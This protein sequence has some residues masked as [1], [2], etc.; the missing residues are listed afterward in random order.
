MI[1]EI[2]ALNP[3]TVSRGFWNGDF[4][5]TKE[6]GSM[7]KE[8]RILQWHPAFYAGVQLELEKEA[9]E[10]AFDNE[11]QLGTKPREIDVLII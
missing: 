1:S 10:L 4:L 8:S 11:H 7:G 2:H 5:Q 9:G 3:N 6:G